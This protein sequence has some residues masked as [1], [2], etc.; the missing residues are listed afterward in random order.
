VDLSSRRACNTSIALHLMKLEQL[1][2]EAIS[3]R[4]DQVKD[5]RKDELRDTMNAWW[6]HIAISRGCGGL[7]SAAVNNGSVVSYAHE[8]ALMDTVKRIH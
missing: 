5:L 7:T 6:G 3:S 1:N 2:G 8:E 4:A